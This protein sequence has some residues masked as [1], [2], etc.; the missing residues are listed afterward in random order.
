MDAQIQGLHTQD[1]P[2]HP[3][4]GTA[5]VQF[6]RSSSSSS[7]LTGRDAAGARRHGG[8]AAGGRAGD[9]GAADEAHV[10]GDRER[11]RAAQGAPAD[12]YIIYYT[13]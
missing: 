5:K 4:S 12:G 3:V 13:L 1:S 11:I 6:Q 7:P 8:G 9:G 2:S 10:G